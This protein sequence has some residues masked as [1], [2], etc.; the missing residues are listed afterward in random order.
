MSG[1][2]ATPVSPASHRHR[3]MMA[4]TIA[5]ILLACLGTY[6]A[7]V[8]FGPHGTSSS[9]GGG[10]KT[11]VVYHNSTIYQNTTNNVTNPVFHN[12]TIWQN[13]TNY[14][15]GTVY[16]TTTIYVNTTEVVMIPVVNVTGL[17][18]NFDPSTS[19]VGKIAATLVSPTGANFVHSYP[20]G[21][22]MWILVNV[23]NHA[24]SSGFLNISAG[25]PFFLIDSQPSVPHWIAKNSVTTIELSIGV[26]YSAGVY[27]LDLNISV[28]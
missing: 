22:V 24:A 15:N 11:I 13:S 1:S 19:F 7:T 27:N 26:P 5:I 3:G 12:S 9:G 20:L 17:A 16:R 2:S 4:I 25:G 10:D 8:T 28:T 23:T 6:W 14:V 18:W 21:T